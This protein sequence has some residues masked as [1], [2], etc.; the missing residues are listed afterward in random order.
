MKKFIALAI[1]VVM[2]AA[3][4]VPAFAANETSGNT[5]VTYSVGETYTVNVPATLELN[6]TTKTGTLTVKLT[7][8][9]ILDGKQVTVTAT[10]DGK[11]GDKEDAF[12]IEQTGT[13]LVDLEDE[14][15]VAVEVV[16][17]PTA[18]GNHAGTITYTI[19]LE[20]ELQ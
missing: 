8:V 19:A 5:V 10:T 6:E 7:A 16:D 4:A 18:A 17:A 9:N 3:L 13:A 20:N 14:V 1:A 12:E 15:V 2:L 11:L